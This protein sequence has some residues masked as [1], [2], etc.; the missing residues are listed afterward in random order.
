MIKN[1]IKQIQWI[2]KESKPF[3]ASI[4]YSTIIDLISMCLSLAAIYFSKQAID[5][6]TG[7]QSGDLWAHAILMIAC[8]LGSMI[9]GILNPWM[10]EKTSLKFQ[11]KMQMLLNGRIMAASWKNAQQWHTGDI[12]NRMVKDCNEVIQLVVYTVPSLCVTLV[13]LMAALVF[14][15][16]L[17]S[18]IAWL[19]LFSTPLLLLSKIYYKRMRKLSKEWKKDDSHV[20]SVLQENTTARM[21]IASLGAEKVR[22]T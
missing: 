10:I 3:H 6:A 22:K 16:V 14:L 5:I 17:D 13:E 7:N 8:I 1:T 9:T 4:L 19:V 21:L 20:T 11:M 12:L 2:R 15:F 18:R